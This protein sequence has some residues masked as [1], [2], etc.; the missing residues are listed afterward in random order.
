M[1]YISLIFSIIFML[2]AVVAAIGALFVEG[3]GHQAFVAILSIVM[4]VVCYKEHR[5]DNKAEVSNG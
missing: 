2:L 1:K 4:T 5:R 3:A